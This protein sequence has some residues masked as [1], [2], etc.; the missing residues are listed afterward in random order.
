MASITV[1]CSDDDDN[2]GSNTNSPNLPFDQI[3][4]TISGA[5][6]GQKTGEC[7]AYMDDVLGE[8]MLFIYG[9][10]GIEVNNPE[11]TFNI[12][13]NYTGSVPVSEGTYPIN[14]D[15]YLA[16]DG[17]YVS[18]DIVDE[19]SDTSENFGTTSPQEGS[20]AI[21]SITATSISGTFA[22][23]ASNSDDD[24]EVTVTQGQFNAL[25]ED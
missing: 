8:Y 4:F 21:S 3:S 16:G 13:F 23:M 24:A 1:S 7:G 10:D 14:Y 20:I 22:F 2:P 19:T 17:F 11:M 6:E 5:D 18:Y 15:A 12:D 25:L 9:N